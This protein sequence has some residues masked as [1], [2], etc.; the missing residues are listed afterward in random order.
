[1]VKALDPKIVPVLNPLVV[2]YSTNEVAFS[3]VVQVITA[4][5]SDVD[6]VAMVDIA[7]AVESAEAVIKES[8]LDVVQLLEG[9]H[10]LTL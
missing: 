6:A 10:D 3:F 7:G 1:M 4:D 2:E 8:A 9:S 5:F